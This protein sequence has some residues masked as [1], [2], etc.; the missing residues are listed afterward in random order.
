MSKFKLWEILL[1]VAV[2]LLGAI[3]Y[4]YDT[5]STRIYEWVL[6]KPAIGTAKYKI[7]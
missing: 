6:D 1:F 4:E 2:L 3:A 7:E 5:T